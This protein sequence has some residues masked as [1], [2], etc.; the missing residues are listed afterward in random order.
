MFSGLNAMA[1]GGYRAKENLKS[2][3]GKDKEDST[4]AVTVLPL[5]SASMR[6]VTGLTSPD[7]KGA[8]PYPRANRASIEFAKTQEVELLWLETV[9]VLR[10]QFLV[11]VVN[12]DSAPLSVCIFL[13][14]PSGSLQSH[15]C[16]IL[17]SSCP[18]SDLR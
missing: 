13:Y 3:T 12:F 15:P 10:I 16:A 5:P 2:G 1:M 7:P 9:K 4:V 17:I 6:P 18:S 11:Q 8:Y 14:F